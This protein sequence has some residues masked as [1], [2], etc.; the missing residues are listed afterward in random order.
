MKLFIV[1]LFVLAFL[2][3][4]FCWGLWL[5]NTLGFVLSVSC[6]FGWGFNVM[7][8]AVVCWVLAGALGEI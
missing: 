7:C 1:I 6:L 5:Y 8:Y 3:L 4:S 2:I